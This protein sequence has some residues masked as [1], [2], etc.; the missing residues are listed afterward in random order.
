MPKVIGYTIIK[1]MGIA[2]LTKIVTSILIFPTTSSFLYFNGSSKILSGL[3]KATKNNI[4]FMKT[5]RPSGP[6]FSNFEKYSKE[7]TNFRNNISQ[8]E[9]LASTIKYEI[10]FGRLDAGDAGEFRVLTQELN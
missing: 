3:N 2:F 7:I 6:D 5:L 9:V 8:L 4:N 1:P 10:S